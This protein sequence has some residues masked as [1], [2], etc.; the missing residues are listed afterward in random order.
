MITIYETEHGAWTGASR[1]IEDGDAWPPTWI[2]VEPPTPA[3]GETPVWNGIVWSL[4]PGWTPPAP[5]PPPVPPQIHKVWAVMVLEA[6]GVVDD[7]EDALDAAWAAG[8][9]SFKRFW[10]AV[11][12]INRGDP[13]LGAFAANFGWSSEQLDQIFIQGAAYEAAAGTNL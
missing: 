2:T 11:G 9:R 13:I 1:Q 7:V 10:S 6:W 12:E 8:N 4:I 5:P 3:E